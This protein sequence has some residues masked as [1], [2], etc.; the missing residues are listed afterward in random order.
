MLMKSTTVFMVLLACILV[1]ACGGRHSPVS[2]EGIRG[3][4]SDARESA[5]AALPRGPTGVM[6]EEDLR[7][8]QMPL[9]QRIIYLQRR[10]EGMLEEM[11][12]NDA[13]GKS[14]SVITADYNK[15]ET[16][17]LKEDLK[18]AWNGQQ[19]GW[20]LSFLERLSG[21]CSR[22]ENAVGVDQLMKIALAFR[23]KWHEQPIAQLR[24]VTGES[25]L[26]NGVHPGGFGVVRVSDAWI[27]LQVEGQ[28]GSPAVG[29]VYEFSVPRRSIPVCEHE[30]LGN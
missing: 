13:G 12:K 3:S 26:I 10:L 17:Q 15:V 30:I 28:G 24:H 4:S 27:P 18:L 2:S 22:W 11:K 14:A 7:V 23:S 5:S 20:K 6:T 21:D 16:T 29:R 19:V 9:E 25:N 8:A 1:A